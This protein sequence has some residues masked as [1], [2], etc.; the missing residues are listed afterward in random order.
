M[1]QR[2]EQQSWCLDRNLSIRV[3]IPAVASKLSIWLMPTL[4]CMKQTANADESQL[5]AI[6]TDLKWRCSSEPSMPNFEPP[7]VG[8][9]FEVDG[10]R[11][12]TYHDL[13]TNVGGPT[14]FFHWTT[15]FLC[16]H[17]CVF[18]H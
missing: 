1:L 6:S 5:M 4:G 15:T 2:V 10:V 18:G 13:A 16:L 7:R 8:L 9:S 17:G 3:C 11:W 14:P 12:D